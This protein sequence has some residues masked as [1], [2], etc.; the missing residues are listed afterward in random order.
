MIFNIIQYI[1]GSTIININYK[2]P[3]SA[4]IQNKRYRKNKATNELVP[5]TFKP[6]IKLKNNCEMA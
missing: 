3:T 5:S 6:Y 2:S 4:T 1:N